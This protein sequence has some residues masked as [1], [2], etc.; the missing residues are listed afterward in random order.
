MPHASSPALQLQD[1]QDRFIDAQKALARCLQA[2]I[3]WDRRIFWRICVI[4][5]LSA[6]GES[7]RQDEECLLPSESMTKLRALRAACSHRLDSHRSIMS[8]QIDPFTRRSRLDFLRIYAE[9]QKGVAT[10]PSG[11]AIPSADDIEFVQAASATVAKR[12]GQL[13]DV[14]NQC[15]TN[16][17]QVFDDEGN[18]IDEWKV[19]E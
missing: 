2:V 16:P 15:K 8:S 19:S 9:T 17:I 4:D 18:L 6:A 14:V 12:L 5:L 13:A 1:R 3:D 7:M 11:G 10:Q